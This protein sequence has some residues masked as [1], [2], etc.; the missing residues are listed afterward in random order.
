MTKNYNLNIKRKLNIERKNKFF[1]NFLIFYIFK[2]LM[3][4][5]ML[6]IF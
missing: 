3:I 5:I 4:R 2:F 1:I 6:E